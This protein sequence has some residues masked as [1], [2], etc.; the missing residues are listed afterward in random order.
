[1][2]PSPPHGLSDQ[3]LSVLRT[4]FDQGP[5]ASLRPAQAFGALAVAMGLDTLAVAKIHEQALAV[6]IAPEPSPVERDARTRRGAIFFTEAMVAIEETHPGARGHHADLDHL[7]AALD[8]RSLDLADSNRQLQLQISG[9]HETEATLKTSEMASGRL[10]RDSQVLEERLQDMA[11]KIRSASEDE[12]KKMSLH[13]ND[14][15]AQTLLGINIR[16][17][18]LKKMIAASDKSLNV[19]ITTIQRLVEESAAII[20]RL[21]HEF[22]FQHPRYAD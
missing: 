2:K 17:L 10:L 9:R 14:E 5:Q 18:A 15:I 16:L 11:G 6:L 8:Q 22:S 20:N 13:L 12:R 7:H 1:M 3:Y 4:Y 21:A 19:E